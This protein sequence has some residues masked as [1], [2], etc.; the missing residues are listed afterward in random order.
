MDF[1][2]QSLGF[3][4]AN[5]RDFV[6]VLAVIGVI[7]LIEVLWPGDRYSLKSRISGLEF[8][9]L[10]TLLAGFFVFPVQWL[11]GQ[12]FDGPLF[13]L[14]F[15]PA[16]VA[17]VA[18]IVATDFL[19][20]WE[21]RFEHRFAWPIHA[22]HHSPAEL[23]AANSFSHPFSRTI[24]AVLIYTPVALID[25]GSAVTPYVIVV[26]LLFQVQV[27]HSSTRLHL[28]PLRWLFVD[29]V[30]HRYHHSDDP[31]HFDRN[32]GVLL[33]IWDRMFGTWHEPVKGEALTFGVKEYP[34]PRTLAGYLTLPF[35]RSRQ[36]TGGVVSAP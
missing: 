11:A 20:Y 23:H 5:A 33:S 19:K 35:R 7:T 27:I 17:V 9:F 24:E 32:F 30:S 25:F 10:G 29:N 8:N 4:W 31:A 1:I 14:A 3:L 12:L 28:G 22:V 21:H 34:E 15:L 6:P 13:S 26:F 2:I 16:P 18:V 36:D